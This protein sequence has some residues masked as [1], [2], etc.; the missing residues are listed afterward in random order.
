MVCGKGLQIV[1]VMLLKSSA[2]GL[3]RTFPVVL[4]L[5][6]GEL[7]SVLCFSSLSAWERALLRS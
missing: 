4:V 1:I 2:A 6:V 3:V 7:E 5:H